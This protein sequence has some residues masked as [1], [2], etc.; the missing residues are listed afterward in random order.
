MSTLYTASNPDSV[1]TD[2]LLIS[3]VKPRNR[4]EPFRAGSPPAA[5]SDSK[6]SVRIR[7]M[8]GVKS[9]VRVDLDAYELAFYLHG[10]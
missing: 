6:S 4:E 8:N 7:S 3:E 9:G 1:D 2:R 10:G 5:S